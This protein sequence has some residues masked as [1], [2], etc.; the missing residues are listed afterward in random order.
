MM[1]NER[2]TVPIRPTMI[3]VHGFKSS[4][5]EDIDDTKNVIHSLKTKFV[6]IRVHS[7]LIK[8]MSTTYIKRL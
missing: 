2:Q 8:H 7:I 3:N 4:A 5:N 1:I 6:F